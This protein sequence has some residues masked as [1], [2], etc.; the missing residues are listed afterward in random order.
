MKQNKLQNIKAIQQMIDGSHRFQTRKT[1]GFSDTETEREKSKRRAIGDIWEETDPVTGIVTVVE[2]RDG[3][4]IKKS[5]NSDV[6]QSVRD[7]VRTF[8]NC[9]KETCTCVKPNHLD[10]K[11][12]KVNGM[13]YDCT[14]E[15]EHDLKKTGEFGT[16]AREKMKKN[17]LAWLQQAE[18][19]VELL[20]Q[21]YTQTA[22]VVTNADGLTETI[23][24]KMTP[25][26]F[27]EKVQKAFNEFKEDFLRKLN[28]ETDEENLELDK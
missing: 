14:I 7:Y 13:C 23:S 8:P 18:Q 1:T 4:R 10:E 20:K 22:K 28:G 24:A 19:E 27:E 15:F 17:A 16:Y 5:K 6:L 9:Q 12:R 25:D 21:V 2:Q 3:F 11:M 26:E